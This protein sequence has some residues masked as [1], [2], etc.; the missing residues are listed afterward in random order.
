MEYQSP[1]F[2]S[3]AP[4]V[5]ATIFVALYQF[6]NEN[7]TETLFWRLKLV[8]QTTEAKWNSFNTLSMLLH[9]SYHGIM[10]IH[11][12]F[13]HLFFFIYWLVCLFVILS[14]FM[15]LSIFTVCSLIPLWI[16]YICLLLFVCIV[17]YPSVQQM[18]SMP[19]SCFKCESMWYIKHTVTVIIILSTTVVMT[20]RT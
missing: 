15:K 1:S 12:N 16:F 13:F 5:D 9:Y 7:F 19:N 2:P 20:W 17:V 3:P 10:I 14:R 4:S 18:L 11:A 6:T 8:V